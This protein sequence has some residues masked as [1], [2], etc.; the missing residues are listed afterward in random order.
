MLFIKADGLQFPLMCLLKDGSRTGLKRLSGDSTLK[1]QDYAAKLRT[2]NVS[3][4][5]LYTSGAPVELF[6]TL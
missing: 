3:I 1:Q 5:Q 6:M 4:S 2:K